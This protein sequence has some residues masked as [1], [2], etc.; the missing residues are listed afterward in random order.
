MIHNFNKFYSIL[1][2]LISWPCYAPCGDNIRDA[3]EECDNGGGVGCT[4]CT[5][6]AGYE[7]SGGDSLQG[8]TWYEICGDGLDLLQWGC[9]DGNT[10]DG[11][12]CDSWCVM[13]DYADCVGGSATAAD[14][15]TGNWGDGRK[16][17]IEEWDD[18]NIINGDG[19]S[20]AW[21]V[22]DGWLCDQGTGG[23]KDIWEEICGDGKNMGNKQCDDKNNYI[24]DGWDHI[25]IVEDGMACSGGNATHYDTW[26]ENCGDGRNIGILPCDDGNLRDGD[27]CSSTCQIETG[28]SWAIDTS[29]VGFVAQFDKCKEIC[30]DGLNFQY[31][32]CDDGNLVNGDGWDSNCEVEVGWRCSYGNSTTADTCWQIIPY[33]TEYTLYPDNKILN[34]KIND[35]ILILN[36]FSVNDWDVYASGPRGTYPLNW[37]IQDFDELRKSEHVRDMNI[38]LEWEPSVQFFGEGIESIHLNLTNP[39]NTISEMFTWPLLQQNITVYPYGMEANDPCDS[40]V[41]KDLTFGLLVTMLWINVFAFLT[42][43]ISM[44][45]TWSLVFVLQ[46]INLVPLTNTYI[47]SCLMWYSKS[48][49]LVNGYDHIIRDNFLARMYHHTEL[50]DMNSYNYRF[51]RYGYIYTSFLDNCADIMMCWVY[52]FVWLGFIVMLWE[53]FRGWKYWDHLARVYKWHMFYRGF[54]VLYLKVILFSMLN[55]YDF[56][57]SNSLCQI[58]SLLALIFFGAFLAYPVIHT[59]YAF[60]YKKMSLEEKKKSFVF[61]EVLFDEFAVYKS[62]QYYYFWQFCAKR[63]IFAIVILFFSDPVLQLWVLM[64]IFVL[65]FVWLIMVRPFKFYIRMFHSGFNDIGGMILTGL[66]FQFTK[67][68]MDDEE[69]YRYARMIMRCIIGLILCNIFLVVAHWF[70]E[71]MFKLFPF[72]CINMRKKFQ[73]AEVDDDEVAPEEEVLSSEESVQKEIIVKPP[74]EI[75]I[76]AAGVLVEKGQE[77]QMERDQILEEKKKPRMPAEEIK[78]IKPS[79]VDDDDMII[80]QQRT[81]GGIDNAA[82]ANTFFGTNTPALGKGKGIFDR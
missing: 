1:L 28:F 60:K 42:F 77:Y 47:P 71:F 55:V 24:G 11:D 68:N 18:N 75:V 76:P 13:E 39:N 40:N 43:K 4:G 21:V 14:T 82:T 22:E 56:N 33:I 73:Q 41:Y 9:D 31:F 79:N 12:G 3:G 35:T 37:H 26:T 10:V 59:G 63:L 65:N 19:C 81:P 38:S 27:G 67:E 6:D 36:T 44:G 15:C 23:R 74:I 50:K 72:W 16:I 45:Y 7:C 54:M 2:A 52:A 30:G 29:I 51:E 34:I 48:M 62:I 20:N 53:V 32:D 25:C 5:V 80:N 69:Y 49:G 8:D 61:S 17:G 66:Y 70:F 57:V 78:E 64:A 46:Y 58:S